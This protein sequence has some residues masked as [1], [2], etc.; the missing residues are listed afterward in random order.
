MSPNTKETDSS[1]KDNTLLTTSFHFKA[2]LLRTRFIH[3][4][5][6]LHL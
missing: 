5:I 1:E 2:S 4:N 6:F 3:T